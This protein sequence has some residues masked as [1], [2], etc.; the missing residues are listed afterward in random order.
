MFFMTLTAD[1]V[2]QDVLV[3]GKIPAAATCE[4][5]FMSGACKRSLSGS[6]FVDVSSSAF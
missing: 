6:S 3:N 4:H 5:A 2:F 1:G